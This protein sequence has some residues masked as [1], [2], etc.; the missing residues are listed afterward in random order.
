MLAWVIGRWAVLKAIGWAGALAWG[1]SKAG[2]VI[3]GQ[4]TQAIAIACVVAAVLF[5]AVVGAV[6][7]SIHDAR[8]SRETRMACVAERDL[9]ALNAQLKQYSDALVARERAL[10]ARDGELQ[11][12]ETRIDQLQREQEALRATS[13]DRDS[14]VF[15]A[16]DPW[17]QRGKRAA[18]AGP[19]G[20]KR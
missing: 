12:Y 18:P 20:P 9:I 10:K 3:A 6:S 1:R 16:D 4:S 11:E 15:A 8:V 2:E 19:T 14:P 7:L 13:P 5:A 17:L